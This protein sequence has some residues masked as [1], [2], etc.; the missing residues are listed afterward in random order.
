MEKAIFTG[1]WGRCHIQGIAAD[2]KGG[3]IIR[4]YRL[5]IMKETELD[6]KRV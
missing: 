3:Y 6:G 2:V 5:F 4:P 1:K